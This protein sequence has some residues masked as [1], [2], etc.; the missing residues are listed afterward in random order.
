[1]SK[2]SELISPKGSIHG[3]VKPPHLKGTASAETVVMPPPDKVLIPMQQHIGVPCEPVVSVG[4]EVFVGTKIGDCEKFISAPVHSSV[5]G[6]VKAIKTASLTNGVMCTAVEIDS[7]GKMTPDPDLKPVDV[8]NDQQL[9]KAVREMGL[10]GLGGAGF[11]THVKLTRQADKPLDTLIINAAECEPYIT[12][13]CRECLEKT[14]DIIDGVYLLL[15]LLKFERVIIAV[16]D[17]KPEAIEALYRV[18]ADR[19]DEENRVRIMKLKSQYPQGA[20]KVLIY[21]ATGRKLPLGKL[22]ADVGCVVMNVTSVASISRYIKTGMPLVSK[23]LTVDGGAI[24]TSQNVEVPI[25]TSVQDVIDFCGGFKTPAKK[26]IIGGPMMGFSIFDT[27]IPVL[28]Q[29]NAVLCF[30][31]READI[32]DI[33]PCIRCGRCE[34]ACPMG[35]SPFHIAAA[36]NTGNTAEVKKLYADYCIECGSC[37]FSCPAKRPIVQVMRKAK[38]ALKNS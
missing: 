18:A 37:A 8:Q 38:Q 30:T 21:T 24:T 13:D 28:K 35:L 1:M 19:R 31:E 17:N 12:A 5:S 3:G 23:R 20:E 2:N 15:K 26:I 6:K 16:E 7:D 10:V 27:S 29:N 33:G 25:G 32:Q 9:V 22:P 34:R 14:E 4:D 11:P 36:L